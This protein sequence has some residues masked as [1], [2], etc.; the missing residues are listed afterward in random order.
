MALVLSV[1]TALRWSETGQFI[2]NTPTRIIE[3][4]LLLVLIQAHNMAIVKRRLEFGAV[5][6]RREVLNILLR[7]SEQTGG[8]EK[9]GAEVEI[10]E[11]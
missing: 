3:G 5:F 1:A 8:D 10:K 11:K 9:C 2:A 6:E 4:F 7:R